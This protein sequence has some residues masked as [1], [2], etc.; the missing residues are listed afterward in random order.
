MGALPSV[1]WWPCVGAHAL[2]CSYLE[3]PKCL[4]LC[5]K[6][7]GM[8]DP[9]ITNHQRIHGSVYTHLVIVKLWWKLMHLYMSCN[10]KDFN[11][12]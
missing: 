10:L 4:W 12:K 8:P 3:A 2:S 1:G 11:V 9:F 5:A 7:Y 6:L